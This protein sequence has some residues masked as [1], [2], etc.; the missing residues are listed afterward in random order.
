MTYLYNKIQSLFT[1]SLLFRSSDILDLNFETV[2]FRPWRD[3]RGWVM[4][5][6][7]IEIGPGPVHIER[8]YHLRIRFYNYC[9]CI[10]T[11]LCLEFIWIYFIPFWLLMYVTQQHINSSMKVWSTN[12]AG[13][14]GKTWFKNWNA[15]KIFLSFY[16]MCPN[17]LLWN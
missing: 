9:Y 13:W 2:E 7:W 15:N 10:F 4:G 12:G 5:N 8:F 6:S 11:H 17:W 1:I 14:I 3:Y 16:K